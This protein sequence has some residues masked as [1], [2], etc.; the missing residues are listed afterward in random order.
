MATYVIQT[1][2]RICKLSLDDC[3]RHAVND[4]ARF[5]LR[6]YGTAR[7]LE[8]ARALTAIGT[9][10]GQY[11]RQHLVTVGLGGRAICIVEAMKMMNHIQAEASGVIESILVENGQPVEFDQPLFT[12]V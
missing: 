7:L 6:P 5:V 3:H 2:D 4:A 12:I 11:H 10:A 1:V 9:H 8:Q